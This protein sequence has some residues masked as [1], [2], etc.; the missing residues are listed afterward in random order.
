MKIPSGPSITW[1]NFFP[2]SLLN[3]KTLRYED[4]SVGQ[5]VAAVIDSVL[6]V[7]IGVSLGS[8]LKGFITKLHWADDPRLKRPELRFKIGDTVTC[9]VLKVSLERKSLYLTCKKSLVEDEGPIYSQASQLA[10]K[11][12]VKG[13][14]SL[15]QTSGI[16]VTFYD[17]LTGWIPISRLQKRGVDLKHFFMGQIVDCVVESLNDTG[18]VVLNLRHV[19]APRMDDSV[20]NAV[21]TLVQCK[22]K[23][24]NVEENSRGLEVRDIWF[25]FFLLY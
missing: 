17:E 20:A 23:Q 25:I 11:T 3:L 5:L 18:R 24:V 9:R 12:A 10:V 21:G 19:D 13:T 6:P 16:L 1:N 14:V 4:F 15:I 2:R 7:G 8:N 22:V